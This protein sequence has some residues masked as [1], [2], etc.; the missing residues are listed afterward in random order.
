MLVKNIGIINGP[1]LNKLGVRQKEIYGNISFE[2]YFRTLQDAFP[3]INLNYFQSNIE[4]CIIDKLQ[5]W[6]ENM[7]GIVLNAGAYTHTSIAI[8]DCLA[9]IDI[10]VIEVHISNIYARESFR[11]HSFVSKYCKAVISGMGLD[12]YLYAIQYL[13]NSN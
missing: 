12:G 4:G 2:T 8:A 10:P 7:D 9:Y 6:N 11:Q 3:N 13:L 5:E 1:N